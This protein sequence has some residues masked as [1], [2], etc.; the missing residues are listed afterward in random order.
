MKI[1]RDKDDWQ[2]PRMKKSIQHMK[3]IGDKDD[4]ETPQILLSSAVVT[5]NIQPLLDPCADDKNSLHFFHHFTKRDNGLE[6]EWLY[7]AFVNPPYNDV[8]KWVAK[9]DE[10]N[11]RHNISIL[12]LVFNKTDTE[13][14]HEYVE[15]KLEVHFIKGRQKFLING[16]N[17]RYCQKCKK[18]IL[19]VIKKCPICNQTLKINT[20]PYPSCW[21]I[22]RKH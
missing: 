21:I 3:I 6:Q 9:A 12:M 5:Y 11:K 1:I 22:W 13:W 16:I 8:D 15:D 10:Q 7:D 4:W 2:K 17:P 20:S 14:W 18:T 19:K